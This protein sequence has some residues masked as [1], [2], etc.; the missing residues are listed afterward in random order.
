MKNAIPYL[1]FINFTL[2]VPKNLQSTF[3]PIFQATHVFPR[4]N[5]TVD[6]FRHVISG[7]CNKSLDN[8][9]RHLHIK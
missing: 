8:N 4:D 5:K 1:I 2:Y 3:F 7:M 9:V 6:L